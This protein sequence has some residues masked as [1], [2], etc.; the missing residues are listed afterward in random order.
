[1]SPSAAEA[2]TL[3]REVWFELRIGGLRAGVA[4]ESVESVGDVVLVTSV[5]TRMAV[6]R[7]GD[8]VE[9]AQDDTW[10]ETAE[11]RALEY[12][13]D[14]C[15]AEGERT[16]LRVLV[17]GDRLVVHKV[18]HGVEYDS[19]VSLDADLVFPMALER[20]HAS[21]GFVPGDVYSYSAFDPDFER[22]TTCSVSVVGR[23]TVRLCG[24]PV[25]L[26]HVR[27]ASDVYERLLIDEWRDDEGAL[28]LQRI[29]HLG[30][31]TR[32]VTSEEAAL[33]SELP[34]IAAAMVVP[35]NVT[36]RDPGR[37]DEA[38]YEIWLEGGDV[39]R[40]VVL[41]ERQA[42]EGRTERGLL[43]RVERSLPPGAEGVSGRRRAASGIPD[44]GQAA[45]HDMSQYLE[46]NALL[47]RDDPAIVEAA[48]RAVSD[49]GDTPWSMAAA[50]SRAVADMMEFRG[51]GTGFASAT[52][53]LRTGRGDCSEHAVLAAAMARAVGLPS[54]V[55]TGLVH[56]D[57]V[58]AYH[59]WVE[60][61]T[62]ENWHG[63][64]PTQ[65]SGG[66]DATHLTLGSSSLEG[67][68]VG[69]LSLPVLRTANRLH[70]RVV[71]YVEAG[72]L[73]SPAD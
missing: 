32:R 59:M 2:D 34:D 10:R 33:E 50:I 62:G 17:T 66:L 37:I 23:D 57:G 55:V 41:D 72:M 20:L 51:Y 26:G 7:F 12:L 67:G 65:G 53:V 54:R 49:A 60:V 48:E 69:E 27:V 5:R 13:S 40:A 11:G 31:E 19:E 29:D 63:F 58:F 18:S 64:D 21:R 28:W 1:L 61:W 73:K 45:A 36:F 22:V 4:R 70:V 43:L 8:R 30:V 3:G 16:L 6:E 14:R 56:F 42:V 52:E 38:L 44:G 25:E 47:Q 39:E 71:E 35:S 9:L 15:L 68:R 46:T 24:R